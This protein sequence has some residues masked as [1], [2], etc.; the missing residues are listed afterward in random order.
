[1]FKWDQSKNRNISAVKYYLPLRPTYTLNLLG[2]FQQ[3]AD[4]C[5]ES[6]YVEKQDMNCSRRKTLLRNT[7]DEGC[8]VILYGKTVE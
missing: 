7:V 2:A 3:V 6:S 1:M 4:I 5:F 8:G